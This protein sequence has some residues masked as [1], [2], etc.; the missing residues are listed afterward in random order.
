MKEEKI[1]KFIE[2]LVPVTAC[3][4]KCEYC[5]VIQE[6]RRTNEMPKFEYSAAH[7]GKALSK[8][9]LGGTCFISF[10]GAGETLLPQ[11]ILDIIKEVLKQGHFVNI[12]TNGTISN[13]FEEIIKWPRKMLEKLFFSFSFHYLEL[14]R[15][16]LL[17]VFFENIDKVKKAGCSFFIQ[18]NLYDGYKPYLEEMRKICIERVG[19]MPQIA[20]TRDEATNPNIKLH[21]KGSCDEYKN[22]VKSFKSKLFDYTLKNFMVR[23][24]EFCYAGKW[25]FTLNIATGMIS[26]CYFEQPYMN[27]YKDLKSPIEKL[28]PVG[29]MCK[30]IYCVNS[31]HFMSLGIIPELKNEPT[32]VQLRDRK[33]AEW[34]KENVYFFLNDKLYFNNKEFNYLQKM[35]INL[36]NILRMIIKKVFGKYKSIIKKF[37][38]FKKERNENE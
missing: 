1:K 23:R 14:Q 11:E 31:S 29:N 13:R 3:N 16:N 19:A 27:I 15:K 26:R 20:V 21:T 10:A 8:E 2:C 9:R 12:T 36:Y 28:P 25:S 24:K 33:N 30:S 6:Q 17:D 7:I 22:C 4:L 5:Y 35:F 34:I 32:Y 18:F 38:V 37:N